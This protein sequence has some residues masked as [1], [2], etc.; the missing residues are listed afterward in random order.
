M[1]IGIVTFHRAYNCGAMLQAWALKTVLSQMGHDV[2]FP[3]CNHVGETPRWQPWCVGTGSPFRIVRSFCY[4]SLVNILS[5]GVDGLSQ[6]RFK[7]FRSRHLPEVDLLPSCLQEYYDLLVY[8]SDQIW[9]AS[10]ETPE[11]RKLFFAE[12]V[13][14][15]LPKI[16][17]A[18]SYDDK[19]LSPPFDKQLG[20]AVAR[21]R[22][23]SVREKL[24]AD[25]ISE[26]T[27]IVPPIVVDPS[28]LL[29]ADDYLKL[30]CGCAPKGEYL[31]VYTLYPTPFVV[32]TAN[33]VA[34]KLGIRVIIAPVYQFSR[35]DAPRGMTYGTSP[36]RL[37][38]YIAHAKYVMS[39][40]FHGTVF[41]L[42]FKKRFLDLRDQVDAYETRSGSLLRQL[43]L[44]DRMANPSFSVEEIVNRLQKPLGNEFED[45]LYQQR[46]SSLDWLRKAVGA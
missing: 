23:V 31:F 15:S 36:E 41:S 35:Y 12:S 25:Q 34:K 5:I 33:A 24:I 29:F 44:T 21:F 6:S 14:E 27:G 37:I 22:S 20:D 18:A 43:G 38:A 1:K 28:L 3:M 17:Y 40:S 45:K 4:R 42:I 16:S 19:P 2:S 10:I 30:D 26:L 32:S 39:M 13:C 8:G 7:R 46:N 9:R 11:E